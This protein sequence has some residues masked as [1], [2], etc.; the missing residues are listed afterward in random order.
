M[1]SRSILLCDASPGPG[2]RTSYPADRN[3]KGTSNM[4][5]CR[6]LIG[7][8]RDRGQPAAAGSPLFDQTDRAWNLALSDPAQLKC[9]PFLGFQLRLIR[10]FAIQRKSFLG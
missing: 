10:A 8:F 2:W 6:R 7:T 9:R 5:V 4:T 1:V 3:S